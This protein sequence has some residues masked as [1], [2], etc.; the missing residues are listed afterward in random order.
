MKSFSTATTA[1]GGWVA[2][3]VL[4]S[5]ASM[6][7]GCV[8][9]A[10][11]GDEKDPGYTD[12]GWTPV[13]P[14]S[15]AGWPAMVWPRDNPYSSAKAVL[16][17]RLFF[18]LA[19]SQD[20]SM[21]CAGCH[22]PDAAYTHRGRPLSHGVNGAQQTR[23]TPTLGN[24]GFGTSFQLDGASASLEAQA[25]LPLLSPDEMGMTEEEI[26]S[27][28]AADTLYVRLFRQAYG[29]API[30]LDGVAKAMATFQRTLV[31]QQ[32]YYDRWKAGDES[33]VSD[34]AKRGEAIFI[35][36][37]GNCAQCHV[38]PLFTD[39][40]FHN[41]GLDSV[42]KDA[43]RGRVTGLA[44]DSGRFKTPSLRNISV[45]GPYMHDARM[46]T[47]KEVVEHYNAGLVDHP[48]TDTILRPLGLTSAEVS[49]L[50]AFLEALTDSVFVAQRIP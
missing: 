11:S 28:L 2:G 5:V 33:A 17:R 8:F 40:G 45:T 50:V 47:L 46:Y 39:N 1:L 9:P 48:R 35:G 42:F 29:N 44:A 4:M 26:V 34:A 22:V 37:K 23:N 25:R 19:L 12:R 14:A 13:R 43:G 31:S 30:T 32:S 10:A 36:K 7:S 3:L 21:S 16:G 41:N 27:R 18:E 20:H 49:D 38:P 15:P 6:V 24:I